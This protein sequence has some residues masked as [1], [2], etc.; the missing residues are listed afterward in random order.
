MSNSAYVDFKSP[1]RSNPV[2]TDDVR[3]MRFINASP[4]GKKQDAYMDYVQQQ[5]QKT[6]Q[7]LQKAGKQ[8][9]VL[10]EPPLP[11]ETPIS[12][13]SK[14]AKLPKD[15]SKS[16]AKGNSKSS[17]RSRR[18]VKAEADPLTFKAQPEPRKSPSPPKEESFNQIQ[19]EIRE[20]ELLRLMRE[21]DKVKFRKVVREKMYLSQF[22]D[23]Y[24]QMSFKDELNA[25][26]KRLKFKEYDVATNST[27]SPEINP[28]SRILAGQ[29]DPERKSQ[30]FKEKTNQLKMEEFKLKNETLPVRSFKEDEFQ[31]HMTKIKAW[32]QAKR[33]KRAVEVMGSLAAF[34]DN[35]LSNQRDN[36]VKVRAQAWSREPFIRSLSSGPRI[37]SQMTLA[38][39]EAP[40]PSA[41]LVES[42]STRWLNR[43]KP[44]DIF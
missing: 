40:Q 21:Q 20:M 16:P 33:E 11:V 10:G 37:R 29:Y 43:L 41:R 17:N 8:N 19:Q 39:T 36:E 30:K 34:K 4:V 14:P 44:T 23:W 1:W 2:S 13:K 6:Q 18:K 27:F 3:I 15:K 35:L 9:K 7:L 5:I 22:N 28:R 26:E 25:F 38:L 32:N 24:S 42:V 31:R 12:Q